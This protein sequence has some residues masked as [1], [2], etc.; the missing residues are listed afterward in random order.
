MSK[1]YLS[2]CN[3]VVMCDRPIVI[4]DNGGFH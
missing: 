3:L 4:F 2:T 1:C